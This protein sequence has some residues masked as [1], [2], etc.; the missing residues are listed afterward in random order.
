MKNKY[1]F[2][3]FNFPK[4]LILLFFLLL[5]PLGLSAQGGEEGA[6]ESGGVDGAGE[7]TP[8]PGSLQGEE[9]FTDIPLWRQALGG[10][11]IG[12]P[13]AQV[14]SVVMATDGGNLK[15]YS[16]QGTPLWDFYARGRLTPYVSR[17]REGTSYICRTNGLLMAVNRAGR[18]LWSI[19]LKA[20]LVSPVL[21]G[22]DGRLFVFT[23]KKITCMTA[24]GY[25]LWSRTLEK[26]LALAP[27]RDTAGGIILVQEDGELISF[28][29]F[30][31]AYSYSAEAVPVAA[32]SME[33][34][35]WGPTVLLL[36]ED[37]GMEL[38]YTSLKY[39]ETYRGKL[40]LPSAPLAAIGRKD[41]AAV[42]L[43][44]GRVALV[45]PGEKKVLWTA[46]TGHIGA[47]ELADLS[48]SGR[49]GPG[50]LELLFD[51]RG[52]YVLT[53]TGATGFAPDGRRLWFIRLRGSAAIP[54]FG[55]DG[56]V[57]SGGVDWILYAYR[58]EDRVRAKQR[59]LYGEAPEGSYGTG[60]PGPSSQADYYYR[61]D[62]TEMEA[63]LAEIRRAVR[64][65]SVGDNE[66]EYTAWLME[67]AGSLSANPRTGNHPPVQARFRV[68]AA[69]LLAYIGSRET[70]PFLA[71]LFNRDPEVLVKA[72]AAEAIGKIG[73]DP[74]GIALKAF[75]D[76]V[77][78][79][80]PTLS[81]ETAL[82]A[83]VG[84]TGA[85]CRFS[86]PPLSYAGIHLLT[87]LSGA[88]KPPMVRSRAQRE[89]KSL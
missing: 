31:N 59:L 36:H 7:S 21:I 15:S 75:E 89:I 8:G 49:P 83:V 2:L 54:S 79:P 11:V 82:S 4:L 23:E 80:S 30:G 55:D 87:I 56:I 24:A 10:A 33:I 72:A 37:R 53:K 29:P 45:S 48:R 34:E 62:E 70:I 66:K 43:K 3:S 38:V 13:A 14:E 26:K 20:P 40:A 25:T 44:D 88:D 28:D 84:A 77:Y 63:R 12:R 74:E 61:F 22:W 6:V 46:A 5:S 78:P 41:Q 60:N 32:A 68:E 58:L 42:F 65:G 76:A 16:S 50:E 73:V 35:G 69:R 27:I 47:G 64:D 19:N 67:T 52:V 71:D 39:G 57:Y 81:D 17:S 85:L 51:E 1:L 9:A 18:E 86:G